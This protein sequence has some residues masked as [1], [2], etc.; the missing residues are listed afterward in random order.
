MFVLI[1]PCSLCGHGGR[2][3]VKPGVQ[4]IVLFTRGRWGKCSSVSVELSDEKDILI[5]LGKLTP[6][7]K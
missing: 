2:W 1:A 6:F 5:T 3:A 4:Q 7:N